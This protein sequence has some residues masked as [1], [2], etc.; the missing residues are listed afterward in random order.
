MIGDKKE[1]HNQ[2]KENWN[3]KTKEMFFTA[4]KE[5]FNL[6]GDSNAIIVYIVDEG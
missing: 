3:L 2:I 1:D 5:A 4:F 6:Y